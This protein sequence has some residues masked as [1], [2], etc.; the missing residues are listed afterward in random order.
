MSLEILRIQ[1]YPFGFPTSTIL[2]LLNAILPY[3]HVK[4]VKKPIYNALKKRF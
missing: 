3:G 1:V 2:H 4:Y